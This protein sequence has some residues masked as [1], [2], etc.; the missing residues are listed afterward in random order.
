MAAVKGQEYHWEVVNADLLGEKG[1]NPQV[2]DL[3]CQGGPLLLT[4]SNQEADFVV[5]RDGQAGRDPVDV[6]EEPHRHQQQMEI[7]D[8]A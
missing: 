4:L 8:C 2:R 5:D 1:P 7:V 3:Q 6:S